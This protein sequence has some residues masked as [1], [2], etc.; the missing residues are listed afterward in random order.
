MQALQY[1]HK[2]LFEPSFTAWSGQRQII[3]FS[4][5]NSRRL[6]IKWNF[7]RL[8]EVFP[9]FATSFCQHFVVQKLRNSSLN[10]Q[11]GI[12]LFS[13]Y[14]FHYTP[15]PWYLCC[16]M[17]EVLSCPQVIWI[18]NT[19]GITQLAQVITILV[20]TKVVWFTLDFNETLY[21]TTICCLCYRC[22]DHVI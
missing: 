17:K 6:A 21:F 8:Q 15:S 18:S 4:W 3:E 16:T 10:Y 1:D 22:A 5:C 2:S 12:S 9:S 20:W 19:I 7:H 13:C 14:A 11:K